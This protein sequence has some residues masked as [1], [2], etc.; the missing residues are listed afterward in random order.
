MMLEKLVP[1]LLLS[2]SDAFLLFYFITFL[3]HYI[4]RVCSNVSQI[5]NNSAVDK[6]SHLE[7]L[8]DN[9]ISVCIK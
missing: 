4:K 9:F 5:Y 2:K 6:S 3:V 1:N 7:A 8:I